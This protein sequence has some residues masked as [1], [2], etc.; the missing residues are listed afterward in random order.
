M[1][2]PAVCVIYNPSSGRGR[3]LRRLDRLRRSLGSRAAFWPTGGP[4]EAEALA[5]RAAGEGFAVVGAAGGDGTAHEVANGLLR[6]GRRDVTLAVL[7]VGSANDYAHSL[8]LDAD[9]WRRNDPGIGPCAVD[10]GVVRSGPRTRFF[11][12]G[13]GLGFNGAVTR[14]SRRIRRLQGVALYG[15]A[16]L[17]ALCFH[18]VAPRAAVSVDGG[19]DWDGPTLALSL[20]LGRREGN[21]V[22][23]P[24]AR[25]AD[26]LFDY[27]HAGALRRRDLLGMLPGLLL[28][29]GL[30]AHPA[31]HTGRC[32]RVA[33]RSEA[34]LTV[35]TDG[36]FF[37]LPEDGVRELEAEVLPGA[38]R[39]FG[40]RDVV[41]GGTPPA[42]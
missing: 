1:A 17:R 39:V 32:R 25:L 38:L 33:F 23:A 28:R 8:G 4:G 12:N 9:W 22:V 27:L 31:L 35:H 14:E 24:D 19:P 15:L 29:G 2:D 21:F 42:V 13:L 40:R 20:A 18:F 30:P 16:V 36:E 3:G 10:A 37:C 26:G 5:L 41:A 11:V 34:P 7:P 6:S